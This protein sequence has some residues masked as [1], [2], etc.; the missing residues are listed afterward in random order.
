LIGTS[1]AHL[2]INAMLAAG[3]LFVGLTVSAL[4]IAVTMPALA[5]TDE[6]PLAVR[7]DEIRRSQGCEAA[8]EPYRQ[9][10]AV[11]PDDGP[12]HF[13]LGYCLHVT[14]DIEAAIEAHARA[15]EFPSYQAAA[16]Y[17]LACAYA[18]SNRADEAI[19]ALSRSIDLGVRDHDRSGFRIATDPDLE[20]LRGDPRFLAQ[21]QRLGGTA[22][23]ID[24]VPGWQPQRAAEGV[25][26]VME[27]IGRHPNA[28]R[29]FSPNEFAARARAIL[30]RVEQLDAETYSLELMRLVAMI[31]DVHT[32]VWV[33]SGT[34]ILTD[35]LP[36]R[37]WR[38]ADGLYVR[39]AS[40]ENADL[41]GARITR[42]GAFDVA[43]GWDRL[44]AENP[45]ENDSM[46][47]GWLQYLLLLPAFHRLNGWHDSLDEAT[48]G[49]VDREGVARSVAL[50]A[51]KDPAY[52]AAL[53]SSLGIADVPEGW[54]RAGGDGPQ[55]PIWLR[56]TTA[57]YRYERLADADGYYLAVNLPRNDPARPWE[58]FLDE[59]FAAV[60]RDGAGKLIVD[61]RHNSGGYAYMAHSLAQRIVRTDLLH[62]P[63]GVCVLTSRTTQSA[64]ITF[65]VLLERETYAIFVG[66][67]GAAAPNFYNGPQGFFSPKAIPGAPLRVKYSTGMIQ[68]SDQRDT[69]R[70]IAP[71]LPVGLTFDDYAKLRDPAL[72][73]CLQLDEKTAAGFLA[74]PGGRPLPLYFHW[75]RPSQHAMFPHGPP[76]DY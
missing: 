26:L 56:E 15:A 53:E 60:V 28:Y 41:V 5:A 76:R 51:V 27:V 12:S 50:A 43:A 30:D 59:L 32:S 21:L 71:D 10:V 7:A 20:S 34:S 45:R 75:R 4:V 11:H 66:E 39:A 68:D 69:R 31:G 18:L 54:V 70:A 67:P 46:A 8:I 17:N 40:P 63:S 42:I 29:Y 1:P 2:K 58:P 23:E 73:T 19:G 6:V 55:T 65:S 49:I 74:D 57:N 3:G 33:R 9:A 25:A 38:F 14:G 44:V 52:G 35:T 72:E 36:L 37:L 47:T 62:R 48:L 61:L 24:A 13:R 64:G 22:L 16:L